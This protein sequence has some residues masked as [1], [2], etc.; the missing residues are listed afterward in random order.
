M[1][2]YGNLVDCAG[3]IYRSRGPER[4]SQPTSV[5]NGVAS[6]R[7][8]PRGHF[9]H[10]DIHV[11]RRESAERF[12]K[13]AGA[14]GGAPLR[15]FRFV[16]ATYTSHGALK[17]K[18]T[19]ARFST[20]LPAPLGHLVFTGFDTA[21]GLLSHRSIPP[22]IRRRRL[23]A[24]PVAHATRSAPRGPERQVRPQLNLEIPT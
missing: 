17:G 11:S 6:R 13:D 2:P 9:N 21:C 20:V 15:R 18:S 24:L 23:S 12:L 14:H 16:P 3:T 19:L 1:L 10:P 8:A 7:S 4:H 5:F 22:R